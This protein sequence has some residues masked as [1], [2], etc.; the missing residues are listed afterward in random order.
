MTSSAPGGAAAQ[1]VATDCAPPPGSGL[2]DDAESLLNELRGLAHDHLN[3]A[4]LEVKRAGNGLV[5]MIAAGIIVAV[6]LV[7]AWIGLLAAGILWLTELG[8][9]PMFAVLLA[10]G[11]NFVLALILYV[12][13]RRQSDYLRFPETIRSLRPK[14]SPA[15]THE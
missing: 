7:S 15:N 5:T 13:I 12:I 4:A 3:L 8:L 6:L 2:L 1:D 9:K 14:P 10:V 11:V